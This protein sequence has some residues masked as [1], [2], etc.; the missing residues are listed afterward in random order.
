MAGLDT[1]GAAGPVVAG[2]VVAGTGAADR[3]GWPGGLAPFG[4]GLGA[5]TV[6]L[7]LAAS[8]PDLDT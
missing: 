7:G 4:D 2:T 5:G 1:G 3:D 8:G 6:T